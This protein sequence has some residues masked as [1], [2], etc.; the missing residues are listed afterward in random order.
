MSRTVSPSAPAFPGH[1]EVISEGKA[2][3]DDYIRHR[4][5]REEEV[6]TVL[7]YG[8]LKKLEMPPPPGPRREMTA[9][10]MVRIIYWDVREELYEAAERGVKLILGKLEGEGRVERRGEER[11]RIVEGTKGAVL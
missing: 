9:M 3:I 1:G 6:L 4:Q 5:Q 10:E 8:S 2:R 11:W 7:R